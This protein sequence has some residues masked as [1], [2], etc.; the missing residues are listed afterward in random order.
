MDVTKIMTD[1]LKLVKKEKTVKCNYSIDDDYVYYTPD[2]YRMYRIPKNLWLIDMSKALPNKT[3]L[4]KPGK[5][6]EIGDAEDAKKTGELKAIEKGTVVKLEGE[7]S[8]VWIN[9]A[10]LKEFDNGCTF[11]INEPK[12]PALV[13]ESGELVGV[14]LPV[15][16]KE[17]LDND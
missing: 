9:E 10:Y 5:F 13:Y 6:F 4:I 3:P 2:G 15:R 8:H 7:R 1:L 14:I 16:V 11:K 12:Y 17:D